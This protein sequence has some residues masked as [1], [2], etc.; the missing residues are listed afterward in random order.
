MDNQI[1]SGLDVLR[2][3]A[4]GIPNE[5]RNWKHHQELMERAAEHVKACGGDWTQYASGFKRELADL[6]K[7]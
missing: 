3:E 2:R 5:E 1:Q 4:R 6:M 7:I